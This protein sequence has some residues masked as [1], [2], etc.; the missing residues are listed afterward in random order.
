[1]HTMEV[2]VFHLLKFS[3]FVILKLCK[4]EVRGQ[5]KM[6]NLF[7]LALLSKLAEARSFENQAAEARKKGVMK[8]KT[9][10]M[11]PMYDAAFPLITWQNILES[12]KIFAKDR[13]EELNLAMKVRK[14]VQLRKLLVRKAL[15]I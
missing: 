10:R 2:T 1:M 14:S 13:I 12:L 4:I 3:F 15:R 5:D 6:K 11:E 7:V 8:L 9:F